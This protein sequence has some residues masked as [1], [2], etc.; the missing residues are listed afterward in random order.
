MACNGDARK[1]DEFTFQLSSETTDR[2]LEEARRTL[3]IE[4]GAVMALVMGGGGT[5]VLGADSKVEPLEE[6]PVGQ[7]TR[8]FGLDTIVVTGSCNAATNTTGQTGS[9]LRGWGNL[10]EILCD[11]N[12]D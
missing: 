7:I 8:V 1:I 11:N 5:A 12:N 2:I 10:A 3:G 6:A 9:H 4:A